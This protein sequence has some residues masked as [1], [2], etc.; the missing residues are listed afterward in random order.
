MN[1]YH[2]IVDTGDR[3]EMFGRAAKHV[4]TRERHEPEAGA[5]DARYETD[6]DG[7]YFP[8][9]QSPDREHFVAAF[10]TEL[11]GRANC[12]DT[13]VRHGEQQRPGFPVLET[14]TTEGAAPVI[15]QVME[16]SRDQLDKR[17]FEVPEGYERVDVLPGRPV[18]SWSNRL[19]MEW[20]VLERAVQ[21]WFR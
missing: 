16:L 2:E 17:L 4:I 12:R 1:I 5:C 6:T 21:S 9:A 11:S 3:R 14:A 15:R 19:D 7:W 8:A 18:M 10:L 13:V 20:S